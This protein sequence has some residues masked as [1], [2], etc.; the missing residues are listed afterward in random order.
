MDADHNGN[1]ATRRSHT[2]VLIFFNKAPIQWYSNKQNTVDTSTFSSEFI[3]LKTAT[4]FVEALWYKLR[5]LGILIEGPTNMFC[6]NEAVYKNA[7]TPESTLKKNNISIC[8]H[9][10]RYYVADRVD[11]IAKEGTATNFDHIVH[12]RCETLLDKFTY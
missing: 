7:S 1:R 2:G 5:V 8:Y 10:C 4:E 3:A 6:D 11:Q 9:K 12:I